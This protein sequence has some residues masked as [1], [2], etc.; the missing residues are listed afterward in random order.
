LK[1]A[2]QKAIKSDVKVSDMIKKILVITSVVFLSACGNSGE[3]ENGTAVSSGDTTRQ[4]VP[5]E[6]QP[7]IAASYMGV[8]PCA[9]CEGIQTEVTLY[10]DTTYKLVTNYLGK[11]PKDTAGLNSNKTGKFMM[12]NDT[13]HLEGDGSKFLKND[14]ALIQLDES[15]KVITGKLADKFILKKVK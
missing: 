3:N 2:G 13:V 14:T 11:N 5:V 1:N 15:G 8:V 6:Y 9:D 4:S 10:A 7:V 12:H